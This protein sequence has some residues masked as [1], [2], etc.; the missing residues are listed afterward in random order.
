MG[1][2]AESPGACQGWASRDQAGGLR[3]PPNLS[4][5]QME[6]C[7]LCPSKPFVTHKSVLTTLAAHWNHLGT[8]WGT[9]ASILPAEAQMKS[10]FKSSPAD[11]NV[12]P[13]W[14]PTELS[15][16][17]QPPREQKVPGLWVGS[18]L[19]K[20]RGSLE[21]CLRPRFLYLHNG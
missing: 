8:F 16:S 12:Q 9:N 7:R 2:S 3:T 17:P 15:S 6:E 18:R 11:S 14:R 10:G 1:G 19:L 4:P 21:Q 20:H 13:G 5:P